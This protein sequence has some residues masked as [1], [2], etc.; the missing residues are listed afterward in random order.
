MIRGVEP[1]VSRLR[2]SKLWEPTAAEHR[3]GA[4]HR[5]ARP[6]S[7]FEH[8]DRSRAP[9]NEIQPGAIIAATKNETDIGGLSE[10]AHEA[11]L[12]GR[13]CQSAS[14]LYTAPHLQIAPPHCSKREPKKL[15]EPH[16]MSRYRRPQD[17]FST[18]EPV[19][20]TC[21]HTSCLSPLMCSSVPRA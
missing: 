11:R 7:L 14:R 19:I 6:A 9:E 21:I 3:P 5:R 20:C 1:L 17:L 13:I 10:S 16:R 12:Q 4:T 8:C 2:D 18:F 15:N